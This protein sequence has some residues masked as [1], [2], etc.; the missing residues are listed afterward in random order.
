[1]GVYERILVPTDGS[2]TS[3]R[4][5]R[6]AAAVAGVH[7][8]DIHVIYALDTSVHAGLP[9]ETAWEGVDTL[10]RSDAEEALAD[11]ER[12]GDELGISVETHLVEGK[13][14]R[15]IVT[16]AED[17]GCDLIV[18]GTQGRGGIDRL[19]LGSVAEKVVRAANIPVTT[20]RNGED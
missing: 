16:F 10:L 14:S 6:H 17:E 1:M 7:D 19:L 11:A 3:E 5:L 12:I 9:M 18:M 20:I 2:P 4:A 8:A 13:P 15:Q